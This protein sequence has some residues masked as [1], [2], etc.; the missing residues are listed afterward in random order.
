MNVSVHN[1]LIIITT[2]TQVPIQETQ[3]HT[4][5]IRTIGSCVHECSHMSV[6]ILAYHTH[7]Y[8]SLK[9]TSDKLNVILCNINIE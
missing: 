4:Q 5:F 2:A 9:D 7:F 1:I 6:C 3:L 8:Q